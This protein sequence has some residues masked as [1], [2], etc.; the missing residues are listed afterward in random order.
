MS[1]C[2]TGARLF[3]VARVHRLPTDLSELSGRL[4]SSL[5]IVEPIPGLPFAH[6][7]AGMSP[8]P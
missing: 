6:C 3:V 7:D 1:S 2:E 4:F 5:M 8:I